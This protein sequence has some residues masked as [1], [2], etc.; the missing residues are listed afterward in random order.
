MLRFSGIYAYRRCKHIH[1]GCVIFAR[2]FPVPGNQI[3]TPN[4]YRD[5]VA[6]PVPYFKRTSVYIPYVLVG[7]LEGAKGV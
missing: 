5:L 4:R 3:Q 6:F 1:V 2:L 7:V